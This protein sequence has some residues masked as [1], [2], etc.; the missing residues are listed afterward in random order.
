M[1]NPRN[2]FVSFCF[3]DVSTSFHLS[4]LYDNYLL[5][6]ETLPVDFGSLERRAHVLFILLFLIFFFYY[7]Y[8]LAP[9]WAHYMQSI[10]MINR[11]RLD[12]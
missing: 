11:M 2:F 12:S 8:Y 3:E 1:W 5:I 10:N 4:A 7:C 6:S 9:K